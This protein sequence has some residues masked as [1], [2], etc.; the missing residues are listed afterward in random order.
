[1]QNARHSKKNDNIEFGK[2]KSVYVL[3]AKTSVRT[4][5][6]GNVLHDRDSYH[7]IEHIWHT[8]TKREK[9]PTNL[10]S[11]P[12]VTANTFSIIVIFFL[13]ISVYT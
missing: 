7:L 5:F 1:M 9:K 11:M 12:F 6:R 4:H 13:L 8:H 2:W 3:N 10:I